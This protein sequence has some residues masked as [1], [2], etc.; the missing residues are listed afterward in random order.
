MRRY[1]KLH[2]SAGPCD[3]A[4]RSSA[5][6]DAADSYNS[7]SYNSSNGNTASPSGSPT[8]V[9]TGQQPRAALMTFSVRYLLTFVSGYH[10]LQQ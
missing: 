2:G 1:A 8:A 9:S 7:S 3:A 10:H 4:C 6:E 5:A